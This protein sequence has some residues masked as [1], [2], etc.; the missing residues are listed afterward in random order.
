M[1]PNAMEYG[2]DFRY[3]NY[4]TTVQGIFFLFYFHFNVIK[5]IS[6]NIYAFYGLITMM[7]SAWHLCVYLLEHVCSV[8]KEIGYRRKIAASKASTT[9]T[10]ETCFEKFIIHWDASLPYHIAVWI[11]CKDN[12][13]HHH[14]KIKCGM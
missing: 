4:R 3:I 1:K 12:E 7:M 6:K 10:I 14:I 13:E 8:W 2:L 5:T 11:R 9:A